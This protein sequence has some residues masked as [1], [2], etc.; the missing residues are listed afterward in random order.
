[1]GAGAAGA[2]TEGAGLAGAAT[3][4]T[5]WVTAGLGAVNLGMSLVEASKQKIYN[6]Q[7]K[8]PLNKHQKNKKNT[9]SKLL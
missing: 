5:P 9:R 2:A 3:A 1:M 4:A 6:V 8:E 7:L